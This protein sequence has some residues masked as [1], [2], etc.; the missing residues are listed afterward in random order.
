MKLNFSSGLQPFHFPTTTVM[1]DDHEKYLGVV[2]LMLDPMLRIRSYSSA[3]Q[4]LEDLHRGDNRAVPGGG[5]LY[6]WR[7]PEHP[8]PNR[9]LM[10]L[11]VDSI[12]RAMYDPTRFSEVSVVIADQ[13]MPEMDGLDLFRQLRNPH[14]GKV[15]L[16][17]RAD[18]ATAIE[19]F[20][21]GLIDRFIRKNDPQAMEKLQQAILTLQQRYFDRVGALVSEAMALGD[22]HF[23][24]DKAFIPVLQDLLERFP[25]VECY[26][27][28]N[29]TGLLMLDEHGEGRFFMVLTD[30]DMRTHYEIANDLGAPLSILTALRDATALPWFASGDGFIQAD[31]RGEQVRMVPA[32]TI[33]GEH[34]YHYALIDQVQE[35]FQLNRV[36]TYAQWLREQDT[37]A[38]VVER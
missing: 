17:G 3:R 18:D 36:R 26:L 21:S 2:P 29:P 6:R 28:V 8:A 10:A 20:N 1:V 35:R 4:A 19:A 30:D 31:E 7:E 27:H 11:D 9:E 33:R 23:L 12:H 16:T 5:W 37:H 25:A 13:V 38:D 22:V 32:T 15:L 14:V 24:R 34:W